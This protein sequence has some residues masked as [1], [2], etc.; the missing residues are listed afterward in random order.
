MPKVILDQWIAFNFLNVIYCTYLL[1]NFNGHSLPYG[2]HDVGKLISHIFR[3]NEI[4]RDAEWER[5]FSY[6]NINVPEIYSGPRLT[7][8]LDANQAAD[9]VEAF[10]N[11]QVGKAHANTGCETFHSPFIMY[12]RL[13]RVKFNV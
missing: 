4:C 8:P 9:L 7:F 10:R 11:K 12:Y 13:Y 2:F 1:L 3:E 5:Y 6:T